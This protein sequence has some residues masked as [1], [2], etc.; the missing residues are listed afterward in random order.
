[1]SNLRELLRIVEEQGAKSYSPAAYAVMEALVERVEALVEELEAQRP[2][3]V[4]ARIVALT[5]DRDSWERLCRNAEHRLAEAKAE[6]EKWRKEAHLE[7]GARMMGEPLSPGLEARFEKL[8][9]DAEIGKLVRGMRRNV[10]LWRDARGLFTPQILSDVRRPRLGWWDS[11]A[12]TEHA[13]EALHS[14]QEEVDE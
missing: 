9:A 8:K 13:V 4:D 7:M 12:S 14:I 10:R 2:P 11:M 6:I 1:M 3:E 5:D